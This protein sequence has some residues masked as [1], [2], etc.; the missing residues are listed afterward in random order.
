[1]E[2]LQIRRMTVADADL[3]RQQREWMFEHNGIDRA[4]LDAMRE[5][6]L[7]WVTRKL[8]DGS[9]I[10][11]AGTRDGVVVAGTGIILLDWPP[12]PQHPLDARRAYVLNVYVAPEE[13]GKGTARLLMTR[14]EDECRALGIDYAVLHASP[15]GRPV[16]ERSGWKGTNEMAKSLVGRPGTSADS[17]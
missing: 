3:I 2:E 10:G 9:Y 5:P 8:T 7:A 17:L 12:H 14:V 13:R 6:F 16:Y 11:W 1:M 4:T 15:M